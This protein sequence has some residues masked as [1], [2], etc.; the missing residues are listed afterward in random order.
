M[1][2]DRC[3]CEK[4]YAEGV[5]LNEIAPA[6]VVSAKIST[7]P[8]Q[9]KVSD[10][11]TYGATLATPVEVKEKSF[12]KK[13]Y[14]TLTKAAS[15]AFKMTCSDEIK[16]VGVSPDG[17]WASFCGTGYVQVEN[18]QAKLVE[19]V[20][21]TADCLWHNSPTTVS[22][23]VVIGEPLAAPH[24]VLGTSE[25]KAVSQ[26]PTQG[27]I[28]ILVGDGTTDEHSWYQICWD[29]LPTCFTGAIPQ[30]EG[31]EILGVPANSTNIEVEGKRCAAALCGEGI[32]RSVAVEDPAYATDCGTGVKYITRPASREE[33]IAYLDINTSGG[34]GGGDGED[35]DDAY[36]VWL[37]AGNTGNVQDFLDSLVGQGSVLSIVDGIWFID[38][39]STGQSAGSDG[40]SNYQLWLEA[41][42]TGTV[43]DYL[44]TLEANIDLDGVASCILELQQMFAS[45]V[46]LSPWLTCANLQA[47]CDVTG[48]GAPSD[49]NPLA[50]ITPSINANGNWFIGTSDTGIPATGPEGPEGPPAEP[51]FTFSDPDFAGFV[52]NAKGGSYDPGIYYYNGNVSDRGLYEIVESVAGLWTVRQYNFTVI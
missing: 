9:L 17:F 48:I 24:L 44:D 25:G 36:Q 7:P 28:S 31:V 11:S 50:G 23:E 19:S 42:N 4:G 18:G 16:L 49:A 32:L 35:G 13:V 12:V 45:L 38:G 41:G 5:P 22:G 14:N 3:D 37:N 46:E 2:D 51:Y 47:Q 39:V 21:F 52:A 34:G 43:Q 15:W 26:K 8:I 33:I 1:S 27:K 29:E 6:P 10:F 30:S 40:Q 20:T